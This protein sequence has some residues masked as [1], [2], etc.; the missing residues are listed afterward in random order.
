MEILGNDNRLAI[1]IGVYTHSCLLLQQDP[2]KIEISH[3]IP[4]LPALAR[5]HRLCVASVLIPW[6]PGPNDLFWAHPHPSTPHICAINCRGR[7]YLSNSTPVQVP[8]HQLVQ[9]PKQVPG[10]A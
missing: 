7:S 1:C 2:N 5:A 9:L 8:A 6:F 4:L 10:Q 3:L